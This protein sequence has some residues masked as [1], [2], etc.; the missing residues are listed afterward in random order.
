MTLWY[1]C[2]ICGLRQAAVCLQSHTDHTDVQRRFE[3]TYERLRRWALS[4]SPD[5]KWFSKKNA[6]FLLSSL[7][8]FKKMLQLPEWSTVQPLCF[9]IMT[10]FSLDYFTG[11]SPSSLTG[12]IHRKLPVVSAEINNIGNKYF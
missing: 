11:K 12:H 8:T 2:S 7:L 5:Q 6:V 3:K 9:H 10:L 4:L 1:K